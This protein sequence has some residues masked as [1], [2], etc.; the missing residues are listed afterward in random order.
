MRIECVL[1]ILRSVY[2]NTTKYHLLKVIHLDK[3]EV[4]Y[5]EVIRNSS[6]IRYDLLLVFLLRKTPD[7]YLVEYVL[8]NKCYPE[9]HGWRN[10]G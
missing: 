6:S 3:Q 2:T 9:V 1:L 8:L 10:A 4:M 7:S 5:S